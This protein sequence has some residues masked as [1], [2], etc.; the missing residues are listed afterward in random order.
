MFL[1][2]MET[3]SAVALKELKAIPIG[4]IMEEAWLCCQVLV[5]FGGAFR[6]L[7]ELSVASNVFIMAASI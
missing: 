4:G 6:C 1:D 2:C 7:I 5:N 3:G